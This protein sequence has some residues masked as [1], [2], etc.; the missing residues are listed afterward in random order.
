[1]AGLAVEWLVNPM[2]GTRAGFCSGL[3]F[4]ARIPNLLLLQVLISCLA[5]P[6]ARKLFQPH[7]IVLRSKRT[8]GTRTQTGHGRARAQR[9]T[10]TLY[11]LKAVTKPQAVSLE[12]ELSVM[13]TSATSVAA[14]AG[15]SRLVQLLLLVGGDGAVAGRVRDA[16]QHVALAHLQQTRRQVE[17]SGVEHRR[18]HSAS[19]SRRKTRLVMPSSEQHCH[20][21]AVDV[22]DATL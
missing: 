15:T 16:R 11:A 9:I 12:I 17:K 7:C 4:S 5:R 8:S 19:S 21:A 14:A 20:H 10:G 1:M 6:G 18:A 3:H 22:P 2:M 13:L